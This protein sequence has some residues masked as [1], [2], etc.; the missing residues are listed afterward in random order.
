MV[1][2]PPWQ[3]R[4]EILCAEKWWFCVECIFGRWI[5]QKF[6]NINKLTQSNSSNAFDTKA[7]HF[8][9][10]GTEDLKLTEQRVPVQCY[11][12]FA[13]SL[14]KIKPFLVSKIVS[15]FPSFLSGKP[16]LVSKIVHLTGLLAIIR[17]ACVLNLFTCFIYEVLLCIDPEEIKYS[18]WKQNLLF[19]T[20][21]YLMKRN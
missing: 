1:Y 18:K 13:R 16:F 9:I 15:A 2:Y 19:F 20:H 12:P 14:F 21:S 7:Y 6:E 8:G 17:N 4:P 10:F 3:S 5:T 11:R